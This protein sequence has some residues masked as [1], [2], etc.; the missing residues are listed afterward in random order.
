M[1]EFTLHS[2][3]CMVPLTKTETILDFQIKLLLKYNIDELIV[4]TGPFPD[5]IKEHIKK[6][7]PDLKVNFFYNPQ[8]STTNYIYSIYLIPNREIEGNLLLLHGDLIVEESLF[9]ELLSSQFENCVLLNKELP[10]SEKDFKG[11]VIDDRITEIGV[12]I[13]DSNCF[14]LMPLYKL[15]ENSFLQWKH[16]I[17]AFIDVGITSVY[18]EDAF[19]KIANELLLFPFYY[20]QEFCM[21]ID[22]PEDLEVARTWISTRK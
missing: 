17:R 10:Q 22:T 13:F 2:P 16:E 12:N 11:R 1:G 6:Q 18:A 3:K 7:Y 8:Y 14:T 21:E 19:N 4:T 5:Q 20:T 15:S 9:S